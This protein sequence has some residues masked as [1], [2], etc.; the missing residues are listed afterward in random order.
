MTPNSVEVLASAL[1]GIAILHTFSVKYFQ[2]IAHKYPSGSIGENFFH[3]LG[4]VEIVFG[5][6]AAVLIGAIG[7][8][9][10]PTEA[11]AF[12]ENCNFTEPT[13]VFVIMAIAATRPVIRFAG[14]LLRSIAHT[15]PIP[16]PLSFYWT[17]LTI[18][19]ILGSFITE[20]AAMTVNALILKDAF[21]DKNVSTRFKLEGSHRGN[22]EYDF[23]ND[24]LSGRIETFGGVKEREESDP[25]V[26]DSR[27]LGISHLRRADR[28][29]PCFY[30]RSFSL[31]YWGDA[32]H[33]GV[34]GRS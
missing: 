30:S 20:P 16:K 32:S 9:R 4:E 24:T 10:N 18:G 6:W 29:S 26:V 34:S 28:T 23:S 3:L 22:T 7:L 15:I 12:V 19:P 2:S 27:S 13:F 1:F 33:T 5:L 11:I 25:L 14:L 17:V 8:I 21:F 31:F